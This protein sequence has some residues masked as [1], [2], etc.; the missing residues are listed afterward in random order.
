MIHHLSQDLA[1]FTNGVNSIKS[2]RFE[3]LSE[4]N[5][6]IYTER[7]VEL[8]HQHGELER[9]MLASGESVDC[10]ALYSSRPVKYHNDLALDLGCELGA[11]GYIKRNG[12]HE[13]TMKGVYAC[14]DVSGAARSIA[15]AVASG[16]LAGISA[17]EALVTERFV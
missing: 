3:R 10:K 16:N 7:I 2:K 9:V 14:G 6:T 4:L 15:V 1:I 12:K 5:I 11:E 8:I 17:H 13:T